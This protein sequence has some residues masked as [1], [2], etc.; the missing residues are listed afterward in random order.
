MTRFHV[1]KKSELNHQ[2]GSETL[3]DTLRAIKPERWQRNGINGG[4][5]QCIVR[6]IDSRCA[7]IM[8]AYIF[9]SIFV[10]FFVSRAR[11]YANKSDE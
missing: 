4:E 2:H 9:F 5:K 3:E 7:D 8:V 1:R 6:G 11:V 10:L